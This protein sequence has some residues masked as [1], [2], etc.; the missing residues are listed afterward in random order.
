MVEATPTRCFFPQAM[1]VIVLATICLLASVFFL[2]VLFQW[3][4]DTKRK[5][6]TRTAADDAAG[7]TGEKKR[8]QIVGPKRTNEKHDRFMERSHR[9]SSTRGRS[10]GCGPGCSECERVVYERVVNSMKP[11]NRS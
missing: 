3:T 1:T 2:F 4:R 8:P 11:G 7:V 9:A 5:T 10:H 6:T